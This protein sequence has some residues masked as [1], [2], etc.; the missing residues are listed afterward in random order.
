MRA[1]TSPFGSWIEKFLAH[2]RALGF[3]Y[4]REEG[5]LSE[6][7]R[8]AA[9]RQ[10]GILTET[11]VRDYLSRLG[12]GSRPNHLTVLRQLARFLVLDEPR[13]FVPSTRFLRIRRRRSAVR[14]L[15]R[16]EAGQFLKACDALPDRMS[17]PRGLVHATGLRVLLLTGLRRG[18]L[19]AL[20]DKDVDLANGVFTVHQS[21]FGKSRFVPLAA[22]L[23]ERLRAYRNTLTTRVTPRRPDDAFFP[24]ADGRQFT[25]PG[26]IYKSF[27]RVLTLAG[28]DHGGRGRGPRLHDLR[29]A[30]AVL[31]MLSWYEQGADLGAK[32][33]L[34][35]TYLGHVELA[36]SQVY[37]HMTHDMVGQVTKRYLKR[38]GDVITAEAS[39]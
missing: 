36:H 26:D 28:I 29:H 22:D 27:R 33:P 11:L 1:F 24:K 30:F 31:R 38:F 7:D 20:R 15:S 34:L 18:E 12:P 10:E 23:A 9:S 32:L 39:P 2:K 6:F 35:A 37:L 16:R 21:K 19:L 14:V 3:T 25:L 4:G 5:F 17:F 13:T 8:F